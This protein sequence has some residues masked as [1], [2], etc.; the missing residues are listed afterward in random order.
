LR[1]II[2]KDGILVGPSIIESIKKIPLP[3]YKKY[4]QS[5]FRKINFVRRFNPNFTEIVKPLNR[6]LKKDA[7][8]QW[9]NDGKKDFQHIKEVITIA[10]VLVS[11]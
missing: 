10:P 3:K 2:S 6:L 7:H 4:L 9:D 11:P 5:F 8:F 1:L